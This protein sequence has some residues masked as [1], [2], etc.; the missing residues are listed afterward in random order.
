M[1]TSFISTLSIQTTM[2]NAISG[3]QR[4]MVKANQEAVTQKHADL[5]V[6]LGANTSRA[7]DLSR[8][9]TRIESL[10]NTAALATQ[11]LESAELA[12]S[13][14]NELGLDIQG[15]ILTLGNSTD[16]TSL[17][18]ARTTMQSALDAFTNFANTSVQ[19]EYIF[20]GI[21]TDVKPMED[22]FAAG[23][24]AKAAFDTELNHYMTTNGIASL[25]VMTET[26]M[27]TFLD[28]LG[29]KFDGT[30]TLTSPPHP[31]ALAGQDFWT[32]FFSDA[33]DENMKSRISQSEVVESST[34]A[35]KAGMRKFAFAS[36]VSLE[37]LQPNMD[38]KARQ[39]VGARTRSVISE[40]MN[41]VDSINQQRTTIGIY[42]ERV[43]KAEERLQAQKDIL[44]KGLIGLE[45][46]D[47]EE[48]ATRLNALKTLL[49]T[50]YTVTAKIQQ[51]S[52]A[53][54]L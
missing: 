25:S 1:K 11:R 52:L 24:P 49:E 23:S 54:F 50:A 2:R 30:A 21:N 34:N 12:L 16:A 29:K 51:L 28:D 17:A 46:V 32:T 38:D 22:Y 6:A 4:E 5:G 8:D 40:A 26:E 42:T 48:A 18:T 27:N 36:I 43:S 3:V 41:G 13:K 37:L 44:T 20:A 31:L 10:Y 47:P 35:N 14:M 7:L 9:I 15:A 53:N 33:S 19:G 39:A 45:N